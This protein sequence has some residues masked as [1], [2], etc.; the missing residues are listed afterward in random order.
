MI[1]REETAPRLSDPQHAPA[2]QAAIHAIMEAELALVVREAGPRT[3][4]TCQLCWRRV[5]PDRLSVQAG[6]VCCRGCSGE[7][8]AVAS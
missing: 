6:T 2:I 3:R 4:L 7:C 5:A 1:A 8:G